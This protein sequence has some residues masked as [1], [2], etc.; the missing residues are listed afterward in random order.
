MGHRAER[1][2]PGLGLIH[3]QSSMN[4]GTHLWPLCRVACLEVPAL[5]CRAPSGL[6]PRSQ[7][8]SLS[9]PA[10]SDMVG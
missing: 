2:C 8:P 5:C 10:P 4:V 3:S 9:L 6:L 7:C 1:R